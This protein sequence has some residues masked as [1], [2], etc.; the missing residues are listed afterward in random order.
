[1][2]SGILA[3]GVVLFGISMVVHVLLWRFRRP[4]RQA[5]AL[6]FIF[7]AP[8]AAGLIFFHTA[9]D[10]LASV[11]AG[12]LSCAYILTYPA[13]QAVSPSLKLLLVIGAA[14]KDG[15][16]AD[17]LAT[18][19][20]EKELFDRRLEDLTDE[21]L[22]VATVRGFTLTPGGFFLVRNF[23]TMRRLLGLPMGRG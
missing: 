22:I 8:V 19:F 21:K 9:V 1:M 14:G 3:H 12:A 13:A 20:D 2:I 5:F 7:L 18:R 16:G 10:I 23:M 4:R 6:F 17:D 15:I 11:F